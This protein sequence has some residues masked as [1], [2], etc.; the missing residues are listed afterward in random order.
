MYAQRN[1]TRHMTID[2]ILTQYIIGKTHKTMKIFLR[3]NFIAKHTYKDRR[4]YSDFGSCS[5]F[6]FPELEN[7]MQRVTRKSLISALSFTRFT[8]DPKM[9]A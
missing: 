4:W 8:S 3:C 9:Y 2:Q 1:E 6:Y 7:N 5:H